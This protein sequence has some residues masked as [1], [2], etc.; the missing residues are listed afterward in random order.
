MYNCF[1]SIYFFQSHLT[2]QNRKINKCKLKKKNEFSHELSF[3]LLNSKKCDLTKIIFHVV[4]T[5]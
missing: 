3:H 5:L 2:K 1:V 4:A